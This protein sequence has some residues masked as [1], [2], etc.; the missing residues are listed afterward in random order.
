[1]LFCSQSID[2]PTEVT[3]TVPQDTV[4]GCESVSDVSDPSMAR[5]SNKFGPMCATPKEAH[6]RGSD[7]L[8]DTMNNRTPLHLFRKMKRTAI[9][10]VV[11]LGLP[12]TYLH[13]Y[14]NWLFLRLIVRPA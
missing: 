6:T 13:Y 14:N 10:A 8:T 3:E 4:D 7:R 2:A 5:V 1:M 9:L 11:K 12:C